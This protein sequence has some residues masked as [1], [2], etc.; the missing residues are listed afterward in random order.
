[1]TDICHPL[2]SP[3]AERSDYFGKRH[4]ETAVTAAPGGGLAYA[5]GR[6]QINPSEG[7]GVRHKQPPGSYRARKNMWA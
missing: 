2:L 6:V 4:A 7:V 1:M 5:F 3:C